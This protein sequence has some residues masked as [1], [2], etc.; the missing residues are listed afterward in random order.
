MS[1]PIRVRVLDDEVEQEW[2]RDGEDYEGVAALKIRGEKEWPWQVAVAAAEF[3]REEPL[4]DDLAD[5]VTSAL[6]AVRGVVEVEHE[7]REV[8]IVSGRPRGKALVVAA[9]AAVDGLA[10]RLR[11][12]LARG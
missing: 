8:W 12:E 10:D 11:Q 9:A 2:I 7:D 4:E 1:K 6:R 5:A 3:V